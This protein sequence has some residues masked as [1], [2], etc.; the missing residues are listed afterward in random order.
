MLL[1]ELGLAGCIEYGENL[2]MGIED[3]GRCTG[4]TGIAGKE[5]RGLVNDQRFPLDDTG[6]HAVSAL[7]ALAPDSAGLYADM[8]GRI[9]KRRIP[10]VVQQDTLAVRQ[11]DGMPGSGQLLVE[12]GHF[13]ACDVEQVTDDLLPLPQFG[14]ADDHGLGCHS[15]IQAVLLVAALPRK[16]RQLVHLRAGDV[17][18]LEHGPHEPLVLRRVAVQNC[19]THAL[20]LRRTD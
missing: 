3:G 19:V 11:H 7:D 1:C 20:L 13:R 8:G 6:A 16:K 14:V 18:S 12:V 15:R 2:A 5:V 9:G 4:Q 10:D 17:I